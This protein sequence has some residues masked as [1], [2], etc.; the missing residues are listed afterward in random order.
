MIVL[1][2]CLLEF[3]F[4]RKN[5]KSKIK[6]Q[7]FSIIFDSLLLSTENHEFWRENSNYPD[8]LGIKKLP[9]LFLFGSIIQIHN[10]DFS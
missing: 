2:R 1:H 9:K 6:I 5:Q 10:F 3:E 7:Q 4:S 8:K